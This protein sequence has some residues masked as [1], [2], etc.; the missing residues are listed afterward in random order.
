MCSDEDHN[1]AD[2]LDTYRCSGYMC[3]WAICQWRCCI[4]SGLLLLGRPRVERLVADTCDYL[5]RIPM[6]GEMESLN[7]SVA[8]GIVIHELSRRR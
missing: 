3:V 1:T 7:A 8:A 5:V 4:W 6:V 2:N